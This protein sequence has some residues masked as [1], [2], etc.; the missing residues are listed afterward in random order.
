MQAMSRWG[1]KIATGSPFETGPGPSFSSKRF[2]C[3]NSKRIYVADEDTEE[4]RSC[5]LEE[6]KSLEW[7]VQ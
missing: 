1:E 3:S 4:K 6:E 5:I 7:S 2:K